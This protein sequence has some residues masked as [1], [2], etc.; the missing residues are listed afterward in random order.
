MSDHLDVAAEGKLKQTEGDDRADDAI[1][2][3]SK[4]AGLQRKMQ[5]G[6]LFVSLAGGSDVSAPCKECGQPGRKSYT[7]RTRCAHVAHTHCALHT[8]HT[9]TL[10]AC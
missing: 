3:A 8:L 10:R 7:L 9:H 1:G 2:E 4:M 5:R 6:Q